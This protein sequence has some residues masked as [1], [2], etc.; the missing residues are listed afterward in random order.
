MIDVIEGKNPNVLKFIHR[1]ND[2]IAESVL[3]KYPSYRERTVM[4]IST[5]S[6]CPVGCTFCGAGK[7]FIR[8]L[9]TEEIVGQVTSMITT[10]IRSEALCSANI[11]KFQIMLMSMGEP[12]LNYNNVEN[13][14][15]SLNR[16]Y[17]QADILISTTAPKVDY[18]NFFNLSKSISKIGLQFSVHES[19]D[20]ERNKLIPFK[21]KLPLEEISVLG[22]N[23][24]KETG[25]TPFINYCVHS[26][27]NTTDDINRIR[28][29]FDPKIFQFTLSVICEKDETVK[30]SIERQELLVTSF[31]NELNK[32]GYSTRVFNPAGQDDIGG[33]CGQLW[34]VQKY[35]NELETTNCEN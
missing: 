16:L 10:V 7:K 26:Y 18:T 2:G 34:Q 6:G 8:N 12:F 35:F 17:P 15:I 11:R 21:R 29:L 14:I 32:Y 1:Y 23:W 28:G 24:Y 31:A 22:W 3:Y 4:C 27:N 30:R 25:R 19:T 33:G 5:Q 20:K 13:A 9:S